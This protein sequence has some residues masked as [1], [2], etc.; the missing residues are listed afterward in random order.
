[1][2]LLMLIVFFFCF[3]FLWKLFLFKAAAPLYVY[4]SVFVCLCL[5]YLCPSRVLVYLLNFKWFLFLFFC[6]PFFPSVFCCLMR[7][8][9]KWKKNKQNC[10][11]CAAGCLRLNFKRKGKKFLFLFLMFFFCC[12]YF[13]FHWSCG[14]F[15]F[16]SAW[17]RFNSYFF[18]VFQDL[19]WKKQ[20]KKNNFKWK[21]VWNMKHCREP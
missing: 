11:Q 19:F 6:F 2:L 9:E 21:N 3:C 14:H 18:S 20:K 1:M 5:H 12:Y 8:E 10:L 17:F 15:R 7:E 4:E 13:F 16:G